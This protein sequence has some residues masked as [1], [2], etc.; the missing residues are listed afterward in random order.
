MTTLLNMG[1][2][3]LEAY[4]RLNQQKESGSPREA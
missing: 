3:A 2:G 4:Q 1:S